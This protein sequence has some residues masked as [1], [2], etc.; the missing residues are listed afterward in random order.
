MQTLAR[1]IAAAAA[2][3]LL[4]LPHVSA[5]SVSAA[6]VVIDPRDLLLNKPSVKLTLA[7]TPT[8]TLTPGGTIN[9]EYNSGFYANGV[10]PTMDSCSVSGLSTTFAATSSSN[11]IVITT[12]AASIV[13]SCSF[14][15]TIG[16]L[17][18]PYVSPG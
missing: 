16:G 14:T 5:T 11:R 13:A 15:N 18:V 3:Q 7:F 8:T 9:I 2:L 12:S 6:R 10:I 17:T 4:L 1:V